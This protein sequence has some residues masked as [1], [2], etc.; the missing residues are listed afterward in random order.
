MPSR[1]T[2]ILASA[3]PR[4][5]DLLRRLGWPFQVAPSQAPETCGSHLSPHEIA[6]LNAH[7]KA[8]TVAVAHPEAVVLA[9]DTI[10]CLGRTIFGKPS[11]LAHA[12]QM[13]GQLQGQTHQVVTGVCLLCRRRR[14]NAI[15]AVSTDVTFR[16]LNTNQIQ[17]YLSSINPLDKAGS[18]A[19]QEQGDWLVERLDGSFSNVVGLPLERLQPELERWL[20][21]D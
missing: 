15:F 6:Q 16:P 20:A 21:P 13:L 7:R 14:A 9:A 1:R 12:A 2:L 19:I 8:G 11:D 18:Y 10:V 3:S 5:L 4:R 17:R